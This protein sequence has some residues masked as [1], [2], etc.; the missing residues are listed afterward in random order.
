MTAAAQLGPSHA[1]SFFKDA[2]HV[3]FMLARYH[4]VARL[5]YGRGRVLELGCGDG[6]GARVVAQ[7]VGSVVGVDRHPY[8]GGFPGRFEQRPLHV[9]W[10]KPPPGA[11]FD[12]AYALDVL[13]HIAP[14]DEH[15]FFANVKMSLSMDGAFICGMPSLESQDY[16]TQDSLREH[17]NCK[18]EGAL[19]DLMMLHFRNVFMFGLNDMTLHCGFGPMCHYRLAVCAG[20]R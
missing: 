13:E 8:D 18:T 9:V 5:F 14:A 6:T 11:P 15:E 16:A 4:Y 10:N 1:A 20:K 12:A 17:V 7:A 3:G 19:R 2:K